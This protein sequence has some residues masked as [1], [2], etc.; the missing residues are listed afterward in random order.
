[1]MAWASNAFSADIRKTMVGVLVCGAYDCAVAPRHDDDNFYATFALGSK[2]A[3]ILFHANAK[4]PAHRLK[5]TAFVD[6]RQEDNLDQ[7]IS[8]KCL[9]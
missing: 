8:V 2:E 3:Q 1:M 6:P 4:C 9:R 7:V 5:I